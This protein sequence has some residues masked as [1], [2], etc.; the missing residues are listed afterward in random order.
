M[1]EKIA[2]S[3]A[4]GQ[5][6]SAIYKYFPVRSTQTN[7]YGFGMY[8]HNSDDVAVWCESN[9]QVINFYINESVEIHNFEVAYRNFVDYC[10]S[11][12]GKGIKTS[13]NRVPNSMGL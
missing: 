10:Q 5:S 7:L 4:G 3:S 11:K 12:L 13:V 1:I 2:S 9:D 6:G 8:M